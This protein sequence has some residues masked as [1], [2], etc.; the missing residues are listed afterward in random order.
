MTFKTDEEYINVL[1]T[2]IMEIRD[3]KPKFGTG[4]GVNLTEF[5]TLYGADPL[6]HWIGFDSDLMYAAHRASGAMTSLYRNLGTGCEHL[7]K[8]L[9]KDGLGLSNANIKWE[10]VATSEQVENLAVKSNVHPNNE[11][12]QEISGLSEDV[13]KKEKRNS[14]DGRI[15]LLEISDLKKRAK[16]KEWLEIQRNEVGISW[17]PLGA[18]FEVRQ[19][20]KS[21]DSKRQSA[22]IANAAQALSRQRI[23][24]LVVFSNQI[25]DQLVKRYRASGWGLMRG[26]LNPNNLADPTINTYAFMRDIVGFD[27]E[28]FFLRN[29]ERIR[30]EVHGVLKDLLK[31]Q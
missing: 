20:Y 22:D 14:L 5:Q 19:G 8:S 13:N 10:Y 21:M 4:G 24:V 16:V 17:E 26:D 25:D 12:I 30:G 27:L 18:V 11:D 15:D 2:K 31:K 29:A 7:F 23:P 28:K 9:I 6:Y 3:Y 1:I